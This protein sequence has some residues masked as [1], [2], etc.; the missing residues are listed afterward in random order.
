MCVRISKVRWETDSARHNNTAAIVQGTLAQLTAFLRRP[1]DH[2]LGYRCRLGRSDLLFGVGIALRQLSWSRKDLLDL[3]IGYTHW[4]TELVEVEFREN[5]VMFLADEYTDR[6]IV[7][8]R[9]ETLLRH[10]QITAQLP[11]IR[12]LG[13]GRGQ[14]LP[15]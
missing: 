15:L 12:R 3:V 5:A 4:E 13:P 1:F 9:V 7:H 2:R 6:R 10:Y 11:E 8:R 14:A